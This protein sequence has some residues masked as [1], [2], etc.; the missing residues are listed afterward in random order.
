[1]IELPFPNSDVAKRCM[2]IMHDNNK[3][4]DYRILCIQV[5]DTLEQ[6][7]YKAE[8]PPPSSWSAYQQMKDSEKAFFTKENPSYFKSGDAGVWLEKLSAARA[9]NHSHRC[10]MLDAV[11]ILRE[12][13]DFDRMNKITEKLTEFKEEADTD[14]MARFFHGSVN[15]TRGQE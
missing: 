14:T 11:K 1:M 4:K 2:E 7:K 13:K 8:P 3:D 10:W 6:V 12:R 15:I 5:D 9:H